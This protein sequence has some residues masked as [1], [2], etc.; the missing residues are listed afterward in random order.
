M[1][2]TLVAKNTLYQVVARLA[3]A[4]I[5][6]LI[7]II[8]AGKFGAVGYGDFTKVTSYVAL[9]Y[10]LVDM[11]FNAIFIQDEKVKFKDFLYFRIIISAVIFLLLNIIAL[12]LPYSQ[13]QNSGFS[14][15]L[16]LGIMIFSIGIFAQGIII[17]SSAV[18]QK[19]LNYFNYM[20]GVVISS[21]VNLLLILLVVF[22]NFSIYFVLASFSVTSLLGAFM[23]LYLTKEKFFPAGFDKQYAKVIFR[24]SFP[25]GLMLIFNLIYFRA[26][27]FLLSIF[28]PAKDV[29]IYGLSYKFF[30]FLIALPLFLS[31][32]IYPFLVSSKN[33]DKIF[34]GIVKK[35]FFVFLLTSFLIVIPFWFISPLFRLIKPD[36]IAAMIPFRILLIS[37]PF[38]FATSLLQWALI[39]REEQKYL[40]Y[41]YFF[42]TVINIFLNL[43]FIPQ[44]S[45]IACAVITVFSEGLV[46]VLLITKIAFNRILLEG[47][48]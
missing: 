15:S 20:L 27:M 19:S 22:L 37:L 18:F 43:I 12:F 8:I 38:F 25:I 14:A 6:F 21:V 16:R 34:F 36:F 24:K 44:Y 11:G 48:K 42:S 10:L 47:G 45:Y 4:F 32:A 9:F 3:T 39:A 31:N 33:L 1:Q 35:Y 46:F 17:S 41:V 40:M 13:V 7:T 26:D 2:T 5:G 29:G 28:S 30:D 23:L